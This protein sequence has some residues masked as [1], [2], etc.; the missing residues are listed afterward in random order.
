MSATIQTDLAVYIAMYHHE[1]HEPSNNQLQ[2]NEVGEVHGNLAQFTTPIKTE[3]EIPFIWH[4]GKKALV[5]IIELS[6]DEKA[7]AKG[8][9]KDCSLCRNEEIAYKKTSGGVTHLI[10]KNCA[11]LYLE[12]VNRLIK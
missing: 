11:I 4:L 12:S 3:V 10:C 8:K 7:E 5:R 1:A 6:E 2:S 9:K